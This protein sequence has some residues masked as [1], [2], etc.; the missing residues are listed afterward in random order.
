MRPRNLDLTLLRT[1]VAVADLGS[2]T[3]AA[4]RLAYTQSAVSMQLQRLER[5]L[6]TGLV[7]R[8]GRR[9]VL[10]DDGGRLLRYARRLLA[11]NDEAWADLRRRPVTGV[12]RLGIPDDYATLLTPILGWFGQLFPAVELEVHC[13]LSVDLVERLRSGGLDLAV[14]TRQRNSPG[15]EVLRS[16]P[17]VWAAS[18]EHAPPLEDPL[19]LALFSRGKDVFRERALAALESAGRSWRVAY[20][21]QS[22]AG[23][24]PAVDAGLAL[25]VI[26][27]SMLTPNLRALDEGSG[28][29]ILPA[30]EIAIHR[31]PGR[32][33]EPT[34]QLASVIQ[35]QLAV[36]RRGGVPV[37]GA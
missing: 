11:L 37:A 26:A 30:V 36:G 19:P 18:R 9:L 7:R 15:G 3:M 2:V 17:L 23:V 31:A 12:V 34:R 35:E 29:P 27:R 8:E 13:A 5:T 4:D 6:E 24:R 16:E 28:L 25:T 1:F 20:T 32:P 22:L 21:S 33:A 10:T 14:V